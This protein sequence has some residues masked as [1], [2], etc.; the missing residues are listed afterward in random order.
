[1]AAGVP[2]DP[3]PSVDFRRVV[4]EPGRWAETL[5]ACPVAVPLPPS[6]SPAPC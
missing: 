3:P 1:M 2:H 4:R 5:S 6:S